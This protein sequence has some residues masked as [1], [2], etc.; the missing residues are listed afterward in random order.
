MTPAEI[1]EFVGGRGPLPPFA[2]T[3][4]GRLVVMGGAKCVWEDLHKALPDGGD[5]MAINDNGQFWRG[6]IRHWVTLHPEYMS[7]WRSYRDKHCY[8]GGA[9]YWVH[10]NRAKEAISHVWDMVNVGGCSG[11]LACHIGLM[12]GYDSIVLC[13]VPMDNSG[14]SF[15][16]PLDLFPGYHSIHIDKAQDAV[17]RKSVR[18]VFKGRVRSMSG[19]TREWIEGAA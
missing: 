11:L 5:L 9:E 7:G 3:C 14:H 18:E 17:W 4:S 13:G 6:R 12:L 2:A 8:G 10:S 1:Y 19:R 15:D 16:P